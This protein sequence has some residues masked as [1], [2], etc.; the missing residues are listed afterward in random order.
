MGL[1][2]T[3]LHSERPKLYTILAFLSAIGLKE[4]IAYMGPNSFFYKMTYLEKRG[5]QQNDRAAFPER[6]PI[7]L[8]IYVYD[9]CALSENAVLDH[10]IYIVELHWLEHLWN[11]E[12]MFKTGV[13]RANERHNT[14][15]VSIFSIM[16][17]CSVFSLES[18]HQG[19]F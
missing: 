7:H 18:P 6:I 16:K 4:R 10:N 5:T 17:V 8:N 11:P 12:N 2:L 1:L 19:D 3:L 14:D 15:I 9:V 13:V